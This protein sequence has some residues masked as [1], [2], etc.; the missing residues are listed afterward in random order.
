LK[1]YAEKRH[2]SKKYDVGKNG[3]MYKEMRGKSMFGEAVGGIFSKKADNGRVRDGC[4]T[5]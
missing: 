4:Y 1:N 5:N 2:F 3:I